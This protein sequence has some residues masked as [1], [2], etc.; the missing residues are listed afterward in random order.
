MVSH[1]KKDNRCLEFKGSEFFRMRL[2]L[3]LLSHKNICISEIKNGGSIPGLAKYQ[4]T[5]LK[6]LEKLTNGSTILIAASG[7]R[8]RFTPG[9]LLGGEHE[10]DCPPD[11]GIGYY[12]EF[13]LYLA[14]FCKYPMEITFKGVTNCRMDCSVD[15]IKYAF[16]PLMKRYIIR[17]DYT[18]DI[19]KRGLQPKGGGEVFFKFPI[20]KQLRPC[21]LID[22]GKVCKIRGVAFRVKCN[23]SHNKKMIHS[24]RSLLNK[25]IPDVYITDD[26]TSVKGLCPGY[27]MCLYA[28][29]TE[30]HIIAAETMTKPEGTGLSRSP[31]EIGKE[32]AM[33]LLD[34]CYLGGCV[35]HKTQSLLCVMMAMNS[36]NVVKAMV[37]PLHPFTQ[38]VLRLLRDF[39]G[40]KFNFK[41]VEFDEE[42][43][44]ERKGSSKVVLSC[45]GIARQNIAKRL[46]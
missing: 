4:E 42:E 25:I 15:H 29:T 41:Q 6:M 11:R 44:G 17:D 2:A 45:R 43:E 46:R 14:P 36:N 10:F 32:A 38:S 39:F 27:G 7:T 26:T 12:L 28:E 35:D 31:D 30:G 5:L 21:N 16:L 19:R 34:E 24:A 22:M 9:V 23:A 18:L 13:L 37:G 3:S 20:I 33:R 1:K 8:V 40:I